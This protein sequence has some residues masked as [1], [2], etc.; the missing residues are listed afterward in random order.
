[1]RLVRLIAAGG[2]V[3]AVTVREG[4]DFR[5]RAVERRP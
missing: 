5:V 2:P 1:L 4:G 3:L